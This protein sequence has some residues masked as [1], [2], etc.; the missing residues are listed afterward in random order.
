MEAAAKAAERMTITVLIPTY[1]RPGDLLRCLMALKAQTRL[2]EEVVVVVRD[3][4]EETRGFLA[5]WETT[6]PIRMVTVCEGGV[7]AAMSAGL[8]EATGE[9]IALTDDD[10]APFADWLERIEAHFDADSKVGGVGGRD[11]QA[12]DLRSCRVV[13]VVQWQGRVIGNHHL[14]VG[15]ARAVDV[16]KGANCAYRA[17]PLKALGF[18][19]R[20]RGGGAQVHWE[21][22]LGL[23]LRQAGWK[24]LYDPAIAMDHFTGA[25][26]DGDL[27]HRGFFNARGVA[28][29]AYNE[30]LIL[31]TYLPLLRRTAFLA[32]A[33]LI[34]THG[35]PGLLQ[36]PRLL[37]RRDKEVWARLKA[38][39]EGRFG[40]M[41]AVR[42]KP[43]H[44]DAL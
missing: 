22:A 39:Y 37:A 13:G 12:H 23:G 35:Q 24:L 31:L 27:N 14:G 4:D 34:G 15:A 30:T 5:A 2:A 10:T 3:S 32:W 6:L 33:L 11:W 7:L 29:S 41:K 42:E 44:R 18:E 43:Q 36:V 1:C 20:L 26:F 19:T 8:A 17:E 21:L 25:R 28:D 9:I 38:T 16:L 40:A